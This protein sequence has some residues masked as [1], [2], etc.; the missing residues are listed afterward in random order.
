[1]I[2]QQMNGS[3]FDVRHELKRLTPSQK[4]EAAV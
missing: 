4:D 3:L 1:M 2:H